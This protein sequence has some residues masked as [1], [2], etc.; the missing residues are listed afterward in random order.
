MITSPEPYAADCA[1]HCSSCSHTLVR[2]NG[3]FFDCP[4]WNGMGRFFSFFRV[5]AHPLRPC[6]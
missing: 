6:R 4:K 2:R 3:T 5:W 1:A